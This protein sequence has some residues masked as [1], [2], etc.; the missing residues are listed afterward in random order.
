MPLHKLG[1]GCSEK[2]SQV[3]ERVGRYALTSLVGFM[4]GT[5]CDDAAS[6][7]IPYWP[8]LYESTV[9][10][11]V[12]VRAGLLNSRETK[13]S[14]FNIELG[15][16]YYLEVTLEILEATD[17]S[18]PKTIDTPIS[19]ASELWAVG[20]GDR[21]LALTRQ[22]GA[23]VHQW[24]PDYKLQKDGFDSIRRGCGRIVARRGPGVR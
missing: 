1:A 2:A 21:F 13:P 5:F 24:T 17:G 20:D 15:E 19:N 22:K 6:F 12:W 10:S 4:L 14:E 9:D 16:R 18:T 8:T 3:Q 23:Y 11:D 7:A